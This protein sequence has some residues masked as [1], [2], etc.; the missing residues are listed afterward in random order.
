M[1]YNGDYKVLLVTQTTKCPL[2]VN[3]WHYQPTRVWTSIPSV[4]T[5]VFQQNAVTLTSD[6]QNLIRSSVRA[7][8][9]SLQ[10]L[11]KLFKLLMRHGG[12]ERTNGRMNEWDNRTV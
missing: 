11:S 1:Q 7:T 2:G 9:Y 10:V 3:R 6:L 8:E 12:N 4:N 5:D